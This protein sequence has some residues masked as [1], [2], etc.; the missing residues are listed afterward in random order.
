VAA[1]SVVKRVVDLAVSGVLLVSLGPVW[2]VIAILIKLDSPGPVFFVQPAIGLNGRTFRLIKFR[3]MRPGSQDESHRADIE[4]NLKL[5]SPTGYDA[6]GRPVFKTAISDRNR[7]TRVGRML[8]KTSLDELPQ[9]WN[10]FAGHM[11]LVGPRPSLPWEAELY[12]EWQRERFDVKP[13]M[14]GLYQVT[15][16]NRV[17]IE[18]MIRIDLDYARRRSL[19]LDIKLLAKTPAAMFH[20]I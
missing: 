10:V 1:Y 18:E 8:R 11:S 4:R 3:S 2:L 17:P 14:T 9:L 19:W 6:K 15:A 16:R 7:I 12:D 20:G 13:G 5:K